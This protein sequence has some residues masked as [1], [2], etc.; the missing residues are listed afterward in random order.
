MIIFM[1]ITVLTETAERNLKEIVKAKL[2][3]A[4]NEGAPEAVLKYCQI[5]KQLG[6]DQQA[7]TKY[8]EHLT[9]VSQKDEQAIFVEL[10]RAGS[11]SVSVLIVMIFLCKP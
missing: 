10:D 7:I 8:V 2:D 1:R 11:S 4:I 6:L 9:R 5:F 3:R